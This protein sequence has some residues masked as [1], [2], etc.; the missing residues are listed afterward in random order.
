M[1]TYYI[2]IMESGDTPEIDHKQL[3][4]DLRHTTPE[5]PLLPIPPLQL[6]NRDWLNWAMEDRNFSPA[7]TPIEVQPALS[8]ITAGFAGIQDVNQ[9]F[10]G[11]VFFGLGLGELVL[12]F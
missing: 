2:S 3:R 12:H 6:D 5:S 7:T 11:L 9:L 8:W 4:S 1:I 10:A